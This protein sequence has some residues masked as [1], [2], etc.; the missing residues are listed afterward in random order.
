VVA[1]L[2]AYAL[3]VSNIMVG[4]VAAAA[5]PSPALSPE[6]P[7]QDVMNRG[8]FSPLEP[9]TY[10]IDADGDRTTPLRVLFD[11]PS[12]GWSAWIG[13][14]KFSDVGHTGISITTVSNLVTDGCRDHAWADPPVG[15]GVDDLVLAMT[16]LHPFEIITEP[17]DVTLAGYPGTHLE[18]MVPEM[19][20]SGAVPDLLFTGCELGKLKSWV[21]FIDADEPRDAFY[22]YTGPGYREEFWIL[23]VDGVRLMI[24]AEHSLG[25]PQTDLDELERIVAS[26][27]IEP[28]EPAS[29]T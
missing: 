6:P 11:I 12:E 24:A 25:T 18:W 23:D 29:G 10:L 5:S 13:A 15:P 27:S 22:G 28:G 14:A 8:P 26:I 20:T 17:T 2:G 4:Q 1:A 21:A 3:I 7:P 9:G 16:A 19:P